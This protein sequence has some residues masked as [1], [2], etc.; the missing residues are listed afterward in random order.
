MIL[1]GARNIAGV[2]LFGTACLAAGCGRGESTGSQPVEFARFPLDAGDVPAGRAATFDP[3][4][5]SD[6]GG[7]LRVVVTDSTSG[8][9]LR[10]YELEHPDLPEGEVMLTGSLRSRGLQGQ[11]I[12]ELRCQ[13]MGENEA[14]VRG[15]RGLVSGDADWTPQQVRFDDPDLCREPESIRISLLML[16]T[17]TV[18]VDDLRLWVLPSE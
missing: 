5:S 14:F 3:E 9:A 2:A 17:G 11:A 8:G 6:G 15:V 10:L 7:S 18:W 1:R 12:L 16:G 4:I 13:P